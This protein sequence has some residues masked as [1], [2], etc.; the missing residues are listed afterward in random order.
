MVFSLILTIVSIFVIL[1]G[2][3]LLLFAGPIRNICREMAK[4]P[5]KIRHVGLA[6]FL[7]GL[8]LLIIGIILLYR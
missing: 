6:E 3:A 4:K 7:V 1:E 8:V 2:L 5:Q